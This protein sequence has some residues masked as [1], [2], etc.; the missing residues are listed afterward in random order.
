MFLKWKRHE[1]I[2]A[3]LR[4]LLVSAMSKKSAERLALEIIQ[5]PQA[6][7]DICGIIVSHLKPSAAKA[8]WVL[9]TASDFSPLLLCHK[10]DWL[11]KSIQDHPHSGARRELLKCLSNLLINRAIDEELIGPLIDLCFDR[12]SA[13]TAATAERYYSMMMLQKLTGLYPELS[14]EFNETLQLIM[15]NETVAFKKQAS[16]IISEIDNEATF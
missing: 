4:D 11:L 6:L 13:P 2:V 16:L 15:Q 1:R 12:L 7:K 10:V 9:R 8:A 3:E 5:D 14:S